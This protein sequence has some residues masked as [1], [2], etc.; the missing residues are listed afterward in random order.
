MYGYRSLES[1]LPLAGQD[2]RHAYSTPCDYNTPALTFEIHT[3]KYTYAHCMP[4]SE[5]CENTVAYTEP[6][7]VVILARKW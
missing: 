3:C 5:H 1:P 2:V 4:I 6:G 7:N